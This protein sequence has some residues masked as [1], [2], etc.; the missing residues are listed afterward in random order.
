MATLESMAQSLGVGGLL[1]TSTAPSPPPKGLLLTAS[2]EISS[3]SYTC[4]QPQPICQQPPPQGSTAM[5]GSSLFGI[6]ALGEI[7]PTSQLQRCGG[8]R[9][10]E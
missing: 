9:E 5:K 6:P 4:K 10:E 1:C 7:S 2:L 3:H 8:T